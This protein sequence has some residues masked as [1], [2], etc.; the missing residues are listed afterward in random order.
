MPLVITVAPEIDNAEWLVRTYSAARRALQRRAQLRHVPADGGGGRL[1]RAA[2]RSPVLRHVRPGPAAA[3]ADVPDARR[4]DGGDALLRRT[5][6]RGDRRRQ[7]PVAR[8]AAAGVQGEGAGP[9]GARDRCDAGGG[10]AR[11]RVLVRRGRQ[12]RAGAE[13]R[14][15]RRDAR[16]HGAGVR[17]DGH[18]PLRADDAP[19]RPGC[20]CRRRCGWRA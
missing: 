4:R 20:R 8:A 15:R 9:A 19:A 11:R 17:R 2:R 13:A 12:R 14:R 7:A 1:G 3:D 5:D 10:H 16:R 6:D 18:G